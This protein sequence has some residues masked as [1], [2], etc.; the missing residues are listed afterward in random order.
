[1]PIVL[2][3]EENE[4]PDVNYIRDRRLP[5]CN[6]NMSVHQREEE[7]EF[8]NRDNGT[9]QRGASWKKRRLSPYTENVSKLQSKEENKFQNGNDATSQQKAQWRKRKVSCK[10]RTIMRKKMRS[11]VNKDFYGRNEDVA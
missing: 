8:P 5:S 3:Q 11:Y 9:I 6:K 10:K 7:N 4:L 2:P 1:M